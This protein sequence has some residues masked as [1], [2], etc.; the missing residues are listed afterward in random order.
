MVS[1]SLLRPFSIRGLIGIDLDT[2]GSNKDLVCAYDILVVLT[3]A[4]YIN[5]GFEFE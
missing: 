2:L 4:V 5:G 1:V 3:V